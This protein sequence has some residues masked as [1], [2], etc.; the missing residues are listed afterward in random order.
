MTVFM[1][2]Q[3]V[4]EASPVMVDTELPSNR[5]KKKMA[6]FMVAHKATEAY[7]AAVDTRTSTDKQMRR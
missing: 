2:A 3:R 6:A 4:V 1:A 7:P 5:G